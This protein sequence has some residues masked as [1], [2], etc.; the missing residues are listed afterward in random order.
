MPGRGGYISVSQNSHSNKNDRSARPSVP[1]HAEEPMTVRSLVLAALALCVGTAC[2]PRPGATGGPVDCDSAAGLLALAAAPVVVTSSDVDETGNTSLVAD[3]ETQMFI[4]AQDP[5]PAACVDRVS[6]RLFF[7]NS[8]EVLAA[9]RAVTQ[10]R[11]Q[12][13]QDMVATDT[14]NFGTVDARF[15]STGTTTNQRKYRA[16]VP[17]R[18]FTGAGVTVHYQWA[19]VID[20]SDGVADDVNKIHV[21]GPVQ[22]FVATA[23]AEAPEDTAQADRPNLVPEL[24]GA[25]VPFQ[26]GGGSIGNDTETYVG[27]D[28]S[29]CALQGAARLEVATVNKPGLGSGTRL[30]V[31]PPAI[32]WRIRNRSSTAVPSTVT[33][34][35]TVTDDY[36]ILPTASH[37]TNGIGANTSVNMPAFSRAPVTVWQ[38]PDAGGDTC[39]ALESSDGRN[40]HPECINFEVDVGDDVTESSDGRIANNVSFGCGG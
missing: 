34:T 6:M 13:G 9:K 24:V 11:D 18:S 16:T 40:P 1:D 32:A 12:D 27:V 3:V 5:L 22:T 21:F 26:T 38:F 4:V 7:A 15:I 20:N 8:P 23:R 36:G 35:S 37:R 29:F 19:K 2:T 10:Q 28:P 33:I 31:R 25:P 39:Y 17:R 14:G 30:V